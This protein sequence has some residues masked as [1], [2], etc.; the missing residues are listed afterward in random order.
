MM[1]SGDSLTGGAVER[2]DMAHRAHAIIG[3]LMTRV[4]VPAW[5][6]AGAIFK[7]QDPSPRLLP[8]NTVLAVAKELDVNLQILLATI[9]GLEL[10]AVALMLAVGRLARPVALVTLGGFCLILI[11]E[12]VMGNVTNCGCLGA[13]SVPPGAMLG[14]DA[15]L[16][17]LAW[18]FV[19]PP[20]A[21]WNRRTMGLASLLAASGFVISFGLVLPAGLPA[22]DSQEST[23]RTAPPAHREGNGPVNPDPA[24]VPGHWFVRDVDSWRGKRWT[25]IELFQYLHRWPRGLD[26]GKRFVVFYN[27]TCDHCEQMFVD[28]LLDPRLAV[29][30]SAIQ[31]PDRKAQMTADEAWPM[32]ETRCEH[33]Q[34]PLGCDWIITT[35]LTLRIE[36]GTVTCAEE[37]THR[38]CMELD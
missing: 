32:P 29:Q 38:E 10:L 8:P 2:C 26:R 20:P 27:R 34:L 4:I 30:V 37:G 18:W 9:I 6:A 1:V 3:P 14:A 31:V 28:D 23:A 22:G 33:L 16:L 13:M 12:L 15:L 21:A 36:D 24:P 19:S 7:L 17:F 11:G 5:V 25:Q 35:P